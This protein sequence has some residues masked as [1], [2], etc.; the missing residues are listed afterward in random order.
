MFSGMEESLYFELSESA[1]RTAGQGT[2]ESDSTA[3]S[4]RRERILICNS[5]Q[6]FEKEG[7]SAQ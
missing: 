1:V 7:Y 6:N 5:C 2:K 3:L 4:D